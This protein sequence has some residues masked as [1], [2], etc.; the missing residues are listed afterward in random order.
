MASAVA[1]LAGCV[2]GLDMSTSTPA[3]LSTAVATGRP[4]RLVSGANQSF[5]LWVDA[6]G[7]WH[8]R[9]TTAGLK[10][11]FQ[12]RIRPA[13][14]VTLTI[15]ETT[16]SEWKDGVALQGADLVFDLITKGHQDGFDFRAS[17]SDCLEFD[18]R[19]DGDGNPNR[20]YIGKDNRTPTNS[21][22]T[23]CPEASANDTNAKNPAGRRG[24]KR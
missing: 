19:I 17:G 21:H 18:L 5:W 6:D 8:L 3:Q 24:K 12:G 11:R 16:A 15:A 14:G 4:T 2:A 23:I 22:F 13:A 1:V 10:R 7:V 20:I 9:S